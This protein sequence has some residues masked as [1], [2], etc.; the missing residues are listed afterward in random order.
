MTEVWAIY[1]VTFKEEAAIRE[2]DNGYD[3]W[4]SAMWTPPTAANMAAT[5]LAYE[6]SG[7]TF[8]LP[9]W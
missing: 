2:A 6:V 8:R 9:K 4:S 1:G 3:S 7:C 5:G